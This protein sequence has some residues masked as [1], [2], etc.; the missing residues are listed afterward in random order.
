MAIKNSILFYDLSFQ[1]SAIKDIFHSR[2]SNV[3]DCNGFI[4]GNYVHKFENQFSKY[5]NVKNVITVNSGTDALF[6]AALSLKLNKNDIVFI[7]TNTYFATVES[8]ARLNCQI[9]PCEIDLESGQ[10]SLKYLE[11]QLSKIRSINQTQRIIVVVVHLF[12]NCPDMDKLV[13][14]SEQYNFTIIEDAAQSHG[15]SFDGKSLGSFGL[16]SSFSFYPAKNLGA[17]GDGGA[18]VTNSDNIGS[19]VRA[20][21]DHGQVEKDLHDSIG[22][23]SRLDEI[24]ALVLSLKIEYLNEWNQQRR[25]IANIYKQNLQSCAQVKLL[26]IHEKCIPNYHLF[27]IRALKRDELIRFLEDEGIQCRIHYPIPMYKQKGFIEYHSEQ[28]DFMETEKFCSQI[29]SLPMYPGMEERD[30]IKI[31]LLI[32]SFYQNN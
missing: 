18:V 28:I 22:I 21:A 4:K 26:H 3:L 12:G 15:S 1:T 17:M 5:L 31:S 7:Q 24:Q 16:L 11:A 29:L 6:L 8:I 23:N 19:K 25:H 30:V 20:L 14:L 13:K 9:K 10:I 2:L 27:V 32:Q